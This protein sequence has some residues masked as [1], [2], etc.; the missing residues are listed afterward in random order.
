[1]KKLLLVNGDIATGK[2]HLANIL[3]ERFQ[4]PLYTKDKI[5]EALADTYPYQTIEQN[6]LLSIMSMNMLYDKFIEEAEKGNDLILEAN[7]REEHLKRIDD[8]VN[9]YGY[10]SL[11]LNLV[12]DI[13]VL[14]ERYVNR[15]Q[16]EGRHP[17]HL[18]NNLFK[19]DDFAE[20]IAAR[21]KEKIYGKCITINA[22]NF[23][24]QVDENLFKQIEEFLWK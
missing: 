7:F 20:Y 19:Y 4:L 10:E 6:H 13:K 11:N 18:V 24:Y 8:A 2:T 9:K 14:H 5:K 17:V 23:D 12:G 22:N 16:N 15:G 21:Q 3:K 1:M